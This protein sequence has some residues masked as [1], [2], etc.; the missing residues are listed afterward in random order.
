MRITIP[1]AFSFLISP[2]ISLGNSPAASQE[3]VSQYVAQAERLAAGDLK[4]LL[5][6]CE[7]APDS[8]ISQDAVDDLVKR[9]IERPAPEPTAVLDNLYYI[10]SAWVS[11][12]ALSTTE[13]IILIDALNNDDEARALIDGG[14]KKIGLDPG[15]IKYVIITHAHGDHY[16]GVNYLKRK[17]DPSIIA[18]NTDWMQLEGQLEYNSKYWGAAPEFN[19]EKDLKAS[20]GDVISL[21]DESLEIHVTAGHTLGTISPVFSARYNNEAHKI[22]LW[23]G[24]AFNFGKDIERLQSYI[25]ATTRMVD[26]AKQQKID[27]MISNHPGYDDTLSKMDKLK[28]NATENPF[29]IGNDAVVRSLLI[30]NNCARAQRDRFIMEE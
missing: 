10:G 20:D 27:V 11:A 12:W 24:T 30:M 22:L 14:M 4:P 29:I 16:G 2:A 23:G 26:L 9:M 18:S 17:Y 7:P 5:R 28:H 1:L 25:D 8:R 6:L 13:G 3:S 15:E 19:A 21:G